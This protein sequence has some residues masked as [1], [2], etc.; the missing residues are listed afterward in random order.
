PL[1]RLTQV[2]YPLGY[3]PGCDEV[4]STLVCQ[5]VDGCGPPLAGFPAAHAQ[6]PRSP[7]AD[8][9]AG[10]QRDGGVADVSGEPTGT[11]VSRLRPAALRH[12]PPRYPPPRGLPAGWAVR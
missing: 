6:L 11:D 3:T 2:P 12:A 1:A 9:G 8:P 7:H 4:A 10:E 5:E